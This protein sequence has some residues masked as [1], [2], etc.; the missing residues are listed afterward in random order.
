MIQA[1]NPRTGQPTGEP[2]PET[3]DTQLDSLVRRAAEAFPAWSGESPQRRA[4][5]LETI[6]DALDANTDALVTVADTE[7][8]LGAQRLRG[9]VARTTGQLR[10]FAQ[11]LREGAYNEAVHSPAAGAGPDLVR[12]KRPVGPV[13]VFAASNFPFA[14]SVMGG[15][16]ASALA[17]GCPVVVKAHEGH[18]GTS[19]ATARI[20]EQALVDAGASIGAFGMVIG[21]EAGLTLL[22]HPLITAAGFTGSTTGGLALAKVCAERPVP[23]PFFGELGAVNP[24]VVLPGAAAGR[25]SE[26]AT[27]YAGSLTLGAG[28]FCTNPGLLFVPEDAAFRSAIADAVG[29]SSGGPM[30]TERIFR[31]YEAAVA[32]ASAHPG[33]TELASGTPGEGPWGATPRVFTTT[34]KEFAADAA[35]L[36]KERFGPAGI[37]ITYSSLDDL[38]PVL[39]DLP[40]NLVG[41]V[42]ADPSAADD[43]SSARRVVPVLER[44]AGRIVFNGWPTGVAVV[45]AQQHGG[46]YPATTA[47]AFTSVGSAAI[48]R[49]L[50][51]VAYQDFPKELL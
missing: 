46:P 50:I 36:S 45:A 7:T 4:E 24:V 23:I 38:L 51:P 18:P 26:I 21:V 20:V 25:G 32:E 42:H 43:L 28:Q 14:F 29:A 22:R 35:T 9:E 1:Y 10:L 47:P 37:V 3:T 5:V 27:G 34:L 40:G 17:A 41:T 11:V 2:V 19:E 31:G 49:W 6:A 30:L 33:V 15:D 12:V 13:A 48:D 8:A 44:I 16:T 39:S